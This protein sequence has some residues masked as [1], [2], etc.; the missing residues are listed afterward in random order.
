MTN[1]TYHTL[2]DDDSGKW[3]VI[4]EVDEFEAGPFTTHEQAKAWIDQ[5]SAIDEWTDS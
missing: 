3:L 2:F 1:H 5:Q 4:N